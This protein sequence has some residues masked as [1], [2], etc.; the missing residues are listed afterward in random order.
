MAGSNDLVIQFLRQAFSEEALGAIASPGQLRRAKQSLSLGSTPTLISAD[1][2]TIELG[3]SSGN[4]HRITCPAA[5]P[6]EATCT[7]PAKTTATTTCIHVLVACLWFRSQLGGDDTPPTQSPAAGTDEPTFVPQAPASAS[8][9]LP[10]ASQSNPNL[11]AASERSGFSDTESNPGTDE[12]PFVPPVPAPASASPSRPDASQSNPNPDAA[13]DHS[14]SGDRITPEEQPDERQFVP[15]GHSMPTVDR[16]GQLMLLD[17]PK[18]PPKPKP[19]NPES[20]RSRHQILQSTQ[21]LLRES[22]TAGLLHLSDNTCQRLTTLAVSATSVDLPRLALALRSINDGIALILTR[23][24]AANSADLLAT[25]AQT[26]ALC[27][28]LQQPSNANSLALMGEARSQYHDVGTLDLAGI[29]AYH[30]ESASG[31]KGLTLIFWDADAQRFYTWSD[32]RPAFQSARFNPARAYKGDGPWDSSSPAELSKARF[33][34]I[35]AKRNAQG[36]LSGSK[37]SKS[38]IRG[39]ALL[40]QL[41]FGAR[42]FNNWQQLKAYIASTLP[43][44][45][46][47]P[48]PLANLVVLQPTDWGEQTF[49]NLSQTL[50]WDILD[51]TGQAIPLQVPYRSY[52]LKRIAYLEALDPAESRVQLIVG[53]ANLTETGLSLYPIS[54]LCDK[55]LSQPAV[56]NLSFADAPRKRRDAPTAPPEPDEPDIA[57][58][59]SQLLATSPLSQPIAQLLQLLEQIADSGCRRL[60]NAQSHELQ[61]QQKMWEKMEA[62]SLVI[63]IAHLLTTASTAHSSVIAEALIRLRYITQLYQESLIQAAVQD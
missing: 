2:L 57:Q 8:P 42:Q 50:T 62:E 26:Y 9:S 58:L 4:S 46:A 5:V 22:L 12:P 38:L 15:T 11:D 63:A 48:D 30:W 35:E 52:D 13:S 37:K 43:M 14:G 40:S 19:E 29:G 55:P 34:L 1:P 18:A 54:L 53:Q 32:S 25:L 7:C 17:T 20:P 3:S 6:A 59:Q 47:I 28:A 27:E 24:A 49:D 61:V 36:R 39:A 10:E 31:F 51:S 60:N 23:N 21:Q 41:N 44:G 33:Q 45:L 16:D 56:T